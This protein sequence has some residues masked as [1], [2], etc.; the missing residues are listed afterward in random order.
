MDVN[1]GEEKSNSLYDMSYLEQK[2]KYSVFLGGNK[3]LVTIKAED[4][5]NEKSI[6]VIKD[7]YAHSMIPLLV[8]NYSTV[9]MIDL[10]YFNGDINEFIKD[11]NITD[12]LALYSFST[13]TSDNSFAKLNR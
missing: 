9:H 4:V 7:S 13:L 6:L 2:D 10:R 12:V 1:N 11:N 3:A 5:D 8:N